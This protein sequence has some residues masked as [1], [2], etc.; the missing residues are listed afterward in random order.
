MMVKLSID[1]WKTVI[2]NIEEEKDEEFGNEVEVMWLE[3]TDEWVLCHGYEI[4]ED[5]F[6]N[7][8]EAME[9]LRE[10]EKQLWH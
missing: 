7:E 8:Y 9:R 3:S 1:S 2:K 4:F 10:I 6:K 5:G